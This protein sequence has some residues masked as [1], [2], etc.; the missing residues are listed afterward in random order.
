MKPYHFSAANRLTPN[1]LDAD[2]IEC[3]ARHAAAG[4]SLAINGVIAWLP[5]QLKGQEWQ[6][7]AAGRFAAPV[8]LPAFL[9]RNQRI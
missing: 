2:K 7:I 1:G 5:V 9:D 8:S 4:R 6:I 3:R